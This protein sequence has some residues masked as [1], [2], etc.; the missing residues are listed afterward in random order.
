MPRKKSEQEREMKE[1]PLQI[2]DCDMCGGSGILATETG[3]AI[4]CTM[5]AGW[6]VIVARELKEYCRFEFT[7]ECFREIWEEMFAPKQDEAQH[8]MEWMTG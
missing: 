1:E 3:C 6:G 2:A 8:D 5:C 7:D 4:I